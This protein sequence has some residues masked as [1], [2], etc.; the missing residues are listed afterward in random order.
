MARKSPENRGLDSLAGALSYFPGLAGEAG[1]KAVTVK[2][3]LIHGL[4]P[5][6]FFTHMLQI[7]L[8]VV[9]ANH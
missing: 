1:V 6:M 8:I 5:G 7:S 2:G 4:L 9:H 3:A